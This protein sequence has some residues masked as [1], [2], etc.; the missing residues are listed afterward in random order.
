MQWKQP[1][2]EISITPANIR[3]DED[4]LM[5]SF[6]FIFKHTHLTHA[7]SEDVLKTSSSRP[8]KDQY[9]RLGHMS[10]RHFQDVFKTSSK[11]VFKI[12]SRRL[13]DVF[14]TS[15]R[16][17][18]I[19]SS[20]GPQNV[21]KTSCKNVFKISSRRLQTVYPV[22]ISWKCVEDIFARH[23]QDIFIRSSRRFEDVFKTFC[24]DVFNTFLR[25]II[26]LNCLSR[27]R[28]CP[29]HTSE[30]FIVSVENLQML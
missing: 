13:Q 9:I 27:S 30:K 11:N 16:C 4:V 23:F 26:R 6:V 21:L 18:A 7:S 10:S 3:L 20:R 28:I 8:D 24:K 14:E 2:K 29:G 22:D 15:S 1:K 25:R 19:T 17:L 12:S 5:T